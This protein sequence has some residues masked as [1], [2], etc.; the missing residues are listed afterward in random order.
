MSPGLNKLRTARTMQ[1]GMCMTIE[2]G[3]YFREFILAGDLDLEKV[4]IKPI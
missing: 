1:K 2:P 3:I 4:G